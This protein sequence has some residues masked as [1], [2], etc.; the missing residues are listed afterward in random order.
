M[1]YILPI[2]QHEY[3]QYANRKLKT[4]V[5]PFVLPP[6]PKVSLEK[7]LKDDNREQ[8]ELET[9]EELSVVS[10][11]SKVKKSYKPNYQLISLI[12]GKGININEVI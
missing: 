12:T 4:G 5:S 10:P 2:T 3:T 11:A 9:S 8:L 7:R 1:G 6:V